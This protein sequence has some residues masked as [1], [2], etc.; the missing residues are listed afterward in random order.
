MLSQVRGRLCLRD[1]DLAVWFYRLDTRDSSEV[2]KAS[3]V[4]CS[5]HD[6]KLKENPRDVKASTLK[7]LEDDRIGIIDQDVHF[8]CMLC[9][10]DSSMGQSTPP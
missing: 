9:H 1:L 5:T 6:S 8:H 7:F 10:Q 3:S 4:D 2:F